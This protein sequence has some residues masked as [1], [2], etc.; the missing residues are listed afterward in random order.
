[1]A[2]FSGWESRTTGF[3]IGPRMKAV[4]LKTIQSMALTCGKTMSMNSTGSLKCLSLIWSAIR[5]GMML[6]S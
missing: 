5:S 4:T 6:V 3:C 1:M 2:V